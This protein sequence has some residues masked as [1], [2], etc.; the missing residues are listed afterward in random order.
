MDFERFA[1]DVSLDRHRPNGSSPRVPRPRAPLRVALVHSFYASAQPSGENQVVRQ[2]V[3]AL[4]FGS[5][6]PP[7]LSTGLRAMSPRVR[8]I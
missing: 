4:W 6:S 2:Q 7:D 1:S 8:K 3:E 5:T